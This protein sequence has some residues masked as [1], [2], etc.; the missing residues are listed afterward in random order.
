MR[1]P[2]WGLDIIRLLLEPYFGQGGEL[3]VILDGGIQGGES[4]GDIPIAR[5]E[6]QDP[7][8]GGDRP[9]DRGSV[10]WSYRQQRLGVQLED[11]PIVGMASKILAEPLDRRWPILLFPSGLTC[12]QR[13]LRQDSPPHPAGDH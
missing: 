8:I 13:L 4:F 1:Q 12:R 10:G 6:L 9:G 7:A 2:E 11:A 5:I 3:P